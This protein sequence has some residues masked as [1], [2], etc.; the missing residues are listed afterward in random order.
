MEYLLC[1]SWTVL[2]LDVTSLSDK[3][4]VN[5]AGGSCGVKGCDYAIRTC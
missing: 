3:D 2:A 1:W 4:C 5:S